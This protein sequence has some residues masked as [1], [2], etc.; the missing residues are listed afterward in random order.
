MIHQNGV[1]FKMRASKS[2]IS[3]LG[4]GVDLHAFQTGNGGHCVA[5]KLS[6]KETQRHEHVLP[7]CT[8]SKDEAQILMD[9][10]WQTGL[11]PSEGTGS[12]GSLKATQNH[13][14]DLKTIL[15]HKMGIK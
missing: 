7:F 13:L 6:F 11:R 1:E 9:D 14:A 15:F 5:E 4:D 12:A 2:P 3:M 10:L 8:L